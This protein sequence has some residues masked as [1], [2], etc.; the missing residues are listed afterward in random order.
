MWQGL[1][2]G[3]NFDHRHGRIV[4]RM[5]QRVTL[6][7]IDVAAYAVMSDPCH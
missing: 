7:A 6:V 2:F 1:L 3:P 4:A 5:G